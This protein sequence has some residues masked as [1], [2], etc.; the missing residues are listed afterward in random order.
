MKKKHHQHLPEIRTGDHSPCNHQYA[1]GRSIYV[2]CLLVASEPG[3][4]LR[5]INNAWEMDFALSEKICERMIE[6]LF[7][8][9]DFIVVLIKRGG[10]RHRFVVIFMA[11]IG[12]QILRRPCSS[13]QCP[14]GEILVRHIAGQP[15][16]DNLLFVHRSPGRQTGASDGGFV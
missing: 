11:A 13:Q 5:R 1:E 12:V 16:I 10:L 7:L 15:P 2:C 6:A 9:S 8:S 4:Q 3:S 14:T